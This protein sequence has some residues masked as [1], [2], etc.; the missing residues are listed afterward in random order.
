[1]DDK[2]PTTIYRLLRAQAKHSPDA[3]AV[4]APRTRP[5]T[6]R[7]LIE[8]VDST[9]AL[10]KA[11]G[12]RRNDRVAIVLPNGPEMAVTF[13]GVCSGAVSAPLN[14]AYREAEFDFYLRDLDAKALI[15]KSGV[16]SPAI[17]VSQ[18]RNIPIITLTLALGREQTVTSLQTKP[19][20]DHDTLM[21]P[22]DVGLL[23]YTSG[24][25][26]KPKQVPLTQRNLLTS[27][28]S[29]SATLALA[30]TDRC[31]NVMPLYHIHGLVGALLSS[32]T[33]GA[34]VAISPDFD[35]GS[36]FD[37]LDKLKPTWYTAVPTI[38]QA[39]LREAT[40]RLAA[41]PRCLRFIR[42]SSAPLS[43]ELMAQLEEVFQTPVIEAYG[44]TEASHQ[45]ASNPLPPYQ[46]KPGSVGVAAPSQISIVDDAGKLLPPGASGEIALRG[47]NITTGYDNNPEANRE[48]F[49]DGWFRTGDQGHL[50]TEGYLFITGRIKEIINRG[51]EK[52]SPYEIEATLQEHPMIAQAVVFPLP[53]PTLGEDVA[54]AV[55]LKKNAALTETEIQ[56]F[57]ALRLADFKTPRHVLIMDEIPTGPTGK[58]QRVN[59]AA[60]L[61]LDLTSFGEAETGAQWVGPQTDTEVRLAEIWREVLRFDQIGIHHSFFE[62]GGDSLTAGQIINR[63]R[64]KLQAE[65]SFLDFFAAPTVAGMAKIIETSTENGRNQTISPQ[66]VPENQVDLPLSFGQERL[67]F[68][69]QF[70]GANVA[71]NRPANL[72]FSGVLNIDALRR[73]LDEIVRRHEV[74]RSRFFSVGGRPIQ[75]I[76]KNMS[77][78]VSISDISDI[79]PSEREAEA[80]RIAVEEAQR[81]FDLRQGPLI[82]GH[83]VRLNRDDHVLLLTVHHMVFDGWSEGILFQELKTLYTAFLAGQPSPLEPLPFQYSDFASMQRQRLRGDFLEHL[84]SYWT[85]QLKHRIHVLDL[86]TDRP[87]PPLQTFRGTRHSFQIT[88]ELSDA[89]RQLGR[90]EKATLFM[91][92][93]AAFQALL[94]RYTN[95]DDTLVGCPI[96]GR[97]VPETEKLIGFFV[98]V[99]VLPAD[100]STEPTF[101]ELLRSVRNNT[102]AALAH[103]D[104]PFEK[105][106][107]EM[108]VERDLSRSPLFQVSFQLRNYPRQ[109]TGLPNLR[110]APFEIGSGLEKYDLSVELLDYDVQGLECRFRYNTDLFDACT[111]VRMGNHFQSLLEGIV[112]NPDQAVSCLPILTASERRHLLVGWNDTKRDYPRNRC[113]HQLFEAQVEQTPDAVAVGFGTQQMTYRELNAQSNQLARHLR[114]L[115]VGPEALVGIC[116]ERSP[117]MIIGILGTLK[118]GGAYVPFDPNYP[119]ERLAFMLA[120]AQTKLLLTQRRLLEKFPQYGGKAICL[121]TDWPKISRNSKENLVNAAVPDNLVYVIYTSGS[122]G[123]PKGVAIQHSGLVNLV[124]WHQDAYSITPADRASQ[125]AGLSFDACAW[126]L[127]PYLTGGA[128]I[129]IADEETRT[130]PSKLLAWLAAQSITTCFLPTPLAEAVL[131]EHWPENLV[132][133]TLLTGGDKLRRIPDK[134]LSFSLVNNYGPTENTVV[135]TWVHLGNGIKKH[136]P[137]PIGRPVANTKIYILDGH[138]EPVPVGVFGELCIVGEGLARNYLNRADLTAEKFVPSPFSDEPGARLYKTGDLARY[139]PDGNIEFLGRLDHQVKIRAFRIEPGEI[140]AALREHPAVHDAVVIAREDRPDD[141]QL[142][143]YVVPQRQIQTHTSETPSNGMGEQQISHWE[144]LFDETFGKALEPEDPKTNTAGVNSSYTNDPLPAVEVRDWVDHAAS[145][146]LS[147][148]PKR[149]LD[150]GCGLGRTLFRLAPYCSR[151]WGTDFCQAALDYVEK[152][153]D[154]LGEKRGEIRL[155]HA[156]AD[157]FSAIPKRHFNTVVINGVIQYFP[158]IDH[159]VKVLE[160]ALD[161]VE[162]GGVIFVGDVRSAPLLE[163]FQLSV[164]LQQAPDDMPTELLWQQVMRNISQEEELVVDPAFFNAIRRL[165]TR[166]TH[167]DILLKRGW[168]QNELT[169]FRYD[170]ILYI[171]PQEQPSAGTAWLDW[172]KEKLTLASIREHLLMAEPRSMGIV[173]VPNARVLPEVRAASSLA[174]GDGPK[175]ASE[176]R[177]TLDTMRANALHPE[178]FWALSN[179]VPYSV[180]ITWSSTGEHEFFDVLLQRRSPDNSRR[181]PA[182]FRQTATAPMPWRSLAHNPVEAKLNRAVRSSLRSFIEK[183]LPSY[184]MPSAFV[185]LAALPLTPN[186]KLD[187]RAL[188]KPDQTS[189]ARE[190]TFV[191]PRTAMEEVLARIWMEV[192]GLENLGVHDNFFDLGGHSLLAT[193]VM[194]RISKYLLVNL[195]LRTLFEK[196]TIAELGKIITTTQLFNQ[197]ESS[198]EG[199]LD[200]IESFSD[201]EIETLRQHKYV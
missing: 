127:W 182:C 16:D 55:V 88:K 74:L 73:A 61:G 186:G 92:L 135:T 100:F 154:L 32:L 124:R 11:S 86:P 171:E 29:I 70:D 80:R 192:L 103:Q 69:D 64:S 67:L 82:R 138:E 165:L 110:V 101:R 35:P 134:P 175:R 12:V 51:G 112:A 159:L 87:R 5:I 37:W 104:L 28:R 136:S 43:P 132:L 77:W 17:A 79:Q 90:S 34:S 121:D 96:A 109:E 183:K 193:Q 46:R 50:D 1:M 72:R 180:D 139:L 93:L 140:E 115:G 81:P 113:I 33:A 30:P 168:A 26:S 58:V 71:Y 150:I 189:D 170:A 148:E 122:T 99:L 21:D 68:F 133:R 49:T 176:L 75:R 144:A 36:F 4:A 106:V 151:Y 161:A 18:R 147:L 84:V 97:N 128:S 200:E 76:H 194:S 177:D 126:E 2:Q 66:T 184:M 178:A 83:L 95:Q 54:A 187:R 149:V 185:V 188:P 129:H 167:T 47:P 42:S 199:M 155:I 141:R 130:S 23:L 6:Y 131:E 118:A 65:I 60:Q 174:R 123:R 44:M 145:R 52:I 3:I 179:E 48:T 142:I 19:P 197:E 114:S 20:S 59:L 117:Q 116:V 94:H 157:D 45:I 56:R 27:A 137:P 163:A 25:T 85:A 172:T 153:L 164:D 40:D 14:P 78:P 102:L 201:D 111:I 63:V 105:L 108:Q 120:D 162:C 7:G 173:G 57:T 9:I 146:I 190:R 31:L 38:H 152:H 143:A 158:H 53:H 91:T 169:R 125:V 198:V 191:A 107:E 24:T 98:N 166:I 41:L 196:P 13:L 89:L 62:L 39:I 22:D 8:Q 195:P 10:L 160:G 15:V 181:S 156:Q 119:V